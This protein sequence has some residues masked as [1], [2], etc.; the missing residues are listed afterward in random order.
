MCSERRGLIFLVFL[1]ILNLVFVTSVRADWLDDWF[2]QHTTSSPN[3]FEAQKRGYLTFGSF[4][5][6][7]GVG[8]RFPLVTLELPRVRGGCGG[9][10]LFLGGFSF[11]NPDYLVQ[12]LQNLVQAA[13]VVAFNLALK[14]LSSSL[15]DEMKWVEDV[16]D[17]L[18][19]LQFDECKLLQPL[20]VENVEGSTLWEKVQNV[21]KQV[22]EGYRGFFYEGRKED[23]ETEKYDETK[24]QELLQECPAEVRK[25]WN[26]GSFL[27]WVGD[28]M[29]APVELVKA[30]RAM[31]G[32]VVVT[33]GEETPTFT[34]IQPV[35]GISDLKKGLG[36]LELVLMDV[37]GRKTVKNVTFL[38]NIT[39][40]LH[41]AYNAK[42]NRRNPPSE[43]IKYAS[44]SPI[45]I[46]YVLN[47]AASAKEPSLYQGVSPVV[48]YG[49][50][51]LLMKYILSEGQIFISHISS[52]SDEQECPQIATLREGLKEMNE[53]IVKYH[54]IME[55]LY[56]EALNEAQKSLDVSVKML[57]YQREISR[58]VL[59]K[60][61]ADVSSYLLGT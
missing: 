27:A 56:M 47:V 26:K 7:T 50:Y 35:V 38:N 30:V 37:N 16:V 28:V 25:I 60:L 58:I 24:K 12:K 20:M 59:Q 51:N 39:N 10:D 4:S 36:Q 23:I 45:P 46:E 22:R 43:Y 15:A 49:I 57:E 42:V 2:E 29:G 11:V 48:A 32:D 19:Q 53:N 5:A 41:Q 6:R 52:P 17:I 18:N 14:T 55:D 8:E 9:I 3:Y 61:G 33:G 1:M 54:K 13:P 21:A 31:T 40:I 44:L 34:Y